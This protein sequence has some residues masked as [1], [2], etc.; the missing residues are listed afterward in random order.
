[1]NEFINNLKRQAEMNPIAAL[2]VGA[3]LMQAASRFM[4]AYGRQVGSRAYARQVDARN[5]KSR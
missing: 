2:A 1:M 3:A 4:D 5:K